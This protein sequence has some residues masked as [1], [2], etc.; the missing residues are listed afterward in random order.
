ME[1]ME[2]G[3]GVYHA[4][5]KVFNGFSYEFKEI[6]DNSKKFKS[7]LTEFLY[8]TSFYTLEELMNSC[9]LLHKCFI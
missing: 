5:I 7:K 6:S 1:S 9:K 3:K 8:S 2:Y 4:A